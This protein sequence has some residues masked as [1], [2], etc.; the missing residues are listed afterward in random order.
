MP[1]QSLSRSASGPQDPHAAECSQP[2]LLPQPLAMDHLD[3]LFHDNPEPTA[4]E[5]P[6]NDSQLAAPSDESDLPPAVHIGEAADDNAP[7][8]TAGDG[9]QSDTFDTTQTFADLG[10]RNSV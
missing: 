10:L 5:T 4:D 8:K 9:D 7:R 1:T 2:I 6:R 3:I